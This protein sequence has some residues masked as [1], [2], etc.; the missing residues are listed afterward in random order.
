[1][2]QQFTNPDYIGLFL[3]VQHERPKTVSRCVTVTILQ[4]VCM[5]FSNAP[6]CF[7]AFF[8]DLAAL[9]WI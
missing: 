8:T 1:M 2:K 6:R 5:K 9:P 4:V 3:E 7:H